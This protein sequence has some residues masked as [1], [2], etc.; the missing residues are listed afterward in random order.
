MDDPIKVTFDHNTFEFVTCPDKQS[1]QADSIE[2]E[3]YL[4]IHNAIKVGKL[5]PFISE[6]ILTIETINHEDR[7]KTISRND[8]VTTIMNMGECINN[9]H[10]A[11]LTIMPNK[12]IYPVNKDHFPYYLLK[13]RTSIIL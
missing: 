6:T 4:R 10:F 11:K 9:Y 2:K 13:F 3:D 5:Q 7:Q 1:K 8:R 12:E